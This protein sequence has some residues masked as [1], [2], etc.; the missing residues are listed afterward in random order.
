MSGAVL[1]YDGTCGFCASS[2]QFVLRQERAGRT[3]RFASLQGETGQSVFRRHPEL[4]GV[5][6]L[7]W[8]EDGGGAAGDVVLVR[9]DGILAVAR[10]L[11]GPWAALARVGR[12]VPRAVRDAMYDFVA[13]NRYR[14]PGKAR[15]CLLPT[16]DERRRFL[17]F[18]GA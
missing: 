2:V 6:S 15:A 18:A 1:L 16:P 13:R 8:Y 4:A 11:G 12:L 17:D 9:S 10:Y 5:D 14:I 7:I 3:L